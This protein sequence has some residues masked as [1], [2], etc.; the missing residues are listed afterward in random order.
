M[1]A[2]VLL[3]GFLGAPSSWDA[4]VRAL[5]ARLDRDVR[6]RLP[7][8]GP[9]PRDVVES[10]DGAPL[11]EASLDA[12]VAAFERALGELEAEID[13]SVA[14]H[15]RPVL[16][17]YS[18]GA[19]L[20]LGLVARRPERY[21]GLLLVSGRDGLA[22]HAE[23]FARLEEDLSKAR[24]LLAGGLEAFVDR[25]EALP[26]FAT[27]RDLGREARAEHRARRLGHDARGLAWALVT[28]SPGAMPTFAPRLASFRARRALVVGAL[29]PKFV[30]L[31]AALA[32]SLDA[33]CSVV[34]NAGHDLLLERPDAVASALEAQLS[35]GARA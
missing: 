5:P 19:R 22:G 28:L 1:R 27:Q 13:R 24:E 26:L 34:P 2:A 8:H 4:V 30:G 9:A 20:A 14:P 32:R 10:L 21:R 23:G 15:E 6:P 35:L 12:R 11:D 18:L 17:G 16:A 29:D 3:H 7:G 33:P 31:G 25:W